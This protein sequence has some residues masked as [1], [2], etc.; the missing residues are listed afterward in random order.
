MTAAIVQAPQRHRLF[1]S[2]HYA[3]RVVGEYRAAAFTTDYKSSAINIL[4]MQ[5]ESPGKK[6]ACL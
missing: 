3:F 5:L 1:A 4:T 2:T 6:S